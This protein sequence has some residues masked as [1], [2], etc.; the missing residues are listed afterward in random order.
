MNNLVVSLVSYNSNI[1]YLEKVLSFAKNSKIK[2]Y[3]YDNAK[4]KTLEKL[5]KNNKFHYYRSNN[6]IGFGAGHNFNIMKSLKYNPYYLI[7]NPDVY[8]KPKDVSNC[9]KLLKN[10]KSYG[11]L[12]PKLV[13]DD[14]TTQFM[15]R[16]IPNILNFFL[17]FIFKTDIQSKRIHKFIEKKK[18]KFFLNIPFIHGACFFIK[19]EVIKKIGLFDDNFFLYL[20]D[21]DFYRRTL[22]KFDTIYLKSV[23]VKHSHSR[24]SRKNF[25]L[26][27][28][29]L[30]SI[31]YYFLKW[32]VFFDF[33]KKKLNKKWL[34]IINHI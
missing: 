30:K 22:E 12:S 21:L 4:Q 26:L 16:L 3:I 5:C 34:S 17:R 7:L 1:K 33:K 9:L 25:K 20:E 19:P 24:E 8:L 18:N 14:G 6:N 13:N 28:I 11:L 15:C 32:G 27:L 10:K 31:I 23:T 2:V 29:H